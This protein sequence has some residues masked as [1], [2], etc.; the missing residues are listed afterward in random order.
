MLKKCNLLIITVIVKLICIP[1]CKK[2]L[3]NFSQ[4]EIPYL[5][6]WKFN[7]L[8]LRFS[9]FYY[10]FSN[11]LYLQFSISFKSHFKSIFFWGGA[12]WSSGLHIRL[13]SNLVRI[14]PPSQI[15]LMVRKLSTRGIVNW[16]KNGSKCER[17]QFVICVLMAEI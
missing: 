15:P 8:N 5:P 6:F 1:E 4:M 17:L 2:E 7:L 11:T 16:R 10:T 14:S 3:G 13:L 12:S 9:I